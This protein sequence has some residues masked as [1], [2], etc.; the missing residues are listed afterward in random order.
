VI[1]IIII[2]V[3]IVIRSLD[4]TL[5]PTEYQLPLQW[6]SRQYVTTVMCNDLMS[7]LKLTRSQLSLAHSDKVKTDMPEKNERQ[8]ESVESVPWVS[9]L[10][11]ELASTWVPITQ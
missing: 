11:S 7:T 4:V 3:F 2:I 1:V 9:A 8:L 10:C 6:W 5:D